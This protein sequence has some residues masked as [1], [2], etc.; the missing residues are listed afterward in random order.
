M[1]FNSNKL[2]NLP[3][4]RFQLP[5]WLRILSTLLFL[6]LGRGWRNLDWNSCRVWELARGIDHS[7]ELLYRLR[8]T[9]YSNSKGVLRQEYWVTD[10]SNSIELF[11]LLLDSRVTD[12]S[13]SI[14]VSRLELLSHWLL[15][16]KEHLHLHGSRSLITQTSRRADWIYKWFWVTDYSNSERTLFSTIRT[17]L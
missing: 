3:N 15:K 8:V 6:S 2:I 5:L 7:T 11:L 14:R 10:Y 12:Y 4:L 1:V 16:L 17:G 9:D 13:N